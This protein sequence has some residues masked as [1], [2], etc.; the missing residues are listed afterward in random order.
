MPSFSSSEILI[1]TAAA[2]G[3]LWIILMRRRG[4]PGLS[5]DGILALKRQGALVLDV[6]TMEEFQQ[7]HLK[8]SLNVPLGSLGRRM[9]E[10]RKDRAILTVCVSGVRSR[11]ACRQLLKAGFRDVHNAGPWRV[12]ED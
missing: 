5:R 1:L 9:G 7:G 3:V 11:M 6:R 8:G 10:L 2:S 12:L 4:R